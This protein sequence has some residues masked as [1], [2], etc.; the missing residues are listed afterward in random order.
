MG[1]K[2]ERDFLDGVTDEDLYNI[3]ECH[4][5]WY[6]YGIRLCLFMQYYMTKK[7][8]QGT[9]QEMQIQFILYSDSRQSK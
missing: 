2:D 4:F 1:V 6:I 7:L 8:S 9:L 5:F 3:G